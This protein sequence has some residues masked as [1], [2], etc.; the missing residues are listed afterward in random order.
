M[1]Q[2]GG[3]V[4]PD[5]ESAGPAPESADPV[6]RQLDLLRRNWEEK[7][8]RRLEAGGG[9]RRR[10]RRRGGGGGDGDDL[11]RRTAQQLAWHERTTQLST[12]ALE[13]TKAVATRTRTANARVKA[14]SRVCECV[15]CC[16]CCFCSL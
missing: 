10:R 9:G 14:R 3:H 1:R 2:R 5:R 13:T 7:R 11:P 15:D 12:K 8:W 16:C 6:W 4:Q